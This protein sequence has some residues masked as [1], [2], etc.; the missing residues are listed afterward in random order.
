MNDINGK[1][2]SKIEKAASFIKFIAF[3]LAIFIGATTTAFADCQVSLQWD[4]NSGDTTAGYRLFQRRQNQSYNYSA[5]AYDGSDNQ[6]TLSNLTEDTVY[7]FVVRAY[8]ENGNMSGDSNEVRFIY[9]ADPPEAP[10]L[11]NPE[12]G[13]VDVSSEPLMATGPFYDP[14]ASDYHTG[15]RWQI[16]SNDSGVCL[17][18]L[19]SDTFLTDFQLPPLLL[20]GSTAYYWTAR[21][22][23][24]NGG[25]S[26]TAANA[27]FTTAPDTSD[28]D[29]D[30]IPDQQEVSVSAVIPGSSRTD[31][32][33]FRAA[34]GD[35][36]IGL[37]TT[38]SGSTALLVAA[39]AVDPGRL[40]TA[41]SAPID[42]PIGLIDYKLEVSQ[43]GQAVSL[44][45]YLSS[46]VPYNEDWL[47]YDPAGYERA[48]HSIH[49]S[50]RQSVILQLQD[51]AQGDMDGVTNG[52]IVG[53]CG[54]GTLSED[55]STGLGG[56][57]SGGGGGGGCFIGV[58]SG[59]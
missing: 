1:T 40:D 49:A 19:T 18:D 34:R 20:D 15:T 33:C 24:Q 45:I 3:T 38:D 47:F 48:W 12:D 57:S 23:N 58:L 37:G 28:L 59:L 11:I 13:A 41:S 4:P 56:S 22:I 25:V 42:L 2:L 8:D 16:F 26:P 46:P 44:T 14:D 10:A 32:K 52:I 53:S 31:L 7:Y 29:M 27:Y 55:Q 43:P 54:Y 9:D 39:Q 21:Y 50:N 5:P 36:N 35:T 6:C 51:G 30:G 17:F